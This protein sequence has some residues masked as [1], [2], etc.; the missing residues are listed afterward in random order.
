MNTAVINIKIEPDT[1]KKA[2]QIADSLGF[3]LSSLINGYLKQLI[4]S[5]SVNFSLSEEPSDYLIQTLKESKSDI[6]A[7]RVRSFQNS[8][9]ALGYLDEMIAYDQRTKN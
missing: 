7:G 5:K 6:K 9:D 2:Q 4:R 1:K 8:Q 3:S